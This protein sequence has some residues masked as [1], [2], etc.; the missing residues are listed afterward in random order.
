MDTVNDPFTG[1]DAILTIT[2]KRKHLQTLESWLWVALVALMYFV[3]GALVG[4]RR[5]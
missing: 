1:A 5:G 2:L 3:L 4:G